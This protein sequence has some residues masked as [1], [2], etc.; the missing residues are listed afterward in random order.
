MT[1]K[2]LLELVI[3]KMPMI[4]A[5]N[6]EWNKD[7]GMCTVVCKLYYN[8]KITEQEHIRITSLIFKNAPT[9]RFDMEYFFPAGNIEK[10]VEF[11]NKIIEKL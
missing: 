6:N 1:D 5:E 10:R 4:K 9:E 7:V 3:E 8:K 2:E 11:I